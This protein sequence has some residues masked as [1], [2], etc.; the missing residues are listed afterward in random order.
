MRSRK[1]A[2][3]G[4]GLLWAVSEVCERAVDGENL[5]WT[6]AFLPIIIHLVIAAGIY[7]VATPTT[8]ATA[9]KERRSSV[10]TLASL[11]VCAVAASWQSGQSHAVFALGL[12]YAF[13][14]PVILLLIERAHREA[15]NPRQNG[16]VIYSTSGLLAQAP[17]VEYTESITSVVRDVALVAASISGIAAI[18]W[19]PWNFAGISS[20]GTLGRVFGDHWVFITGVLDVIHAILAVPLQAGLYTALIYMVSVIDLRFGS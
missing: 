12:S 8:P 9:E 16:N 17:T 4:A 3:Y 19:E 1:L 6:K 18:A 10:L 15:S 14:A 7:D 11:T 13:L 20:W 2:A 5:W